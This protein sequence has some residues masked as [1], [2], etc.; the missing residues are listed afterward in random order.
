MAVLNARTVAACADVDRLLAEPYRQDRVRPILDVLASG[1][2]RTDGVDRFLFT[3][4]IWRCYWSLR[5]E[6][7]GFLIKLSNPEEIESSNYQPWRHSK[8]AYHCGWCD[9]ECQYVDHNIR[10]VSGKPLHH[11]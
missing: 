11:G 9:D 1:H 6:G 5:R 4:M 3:I 8:H 7:E 2:R 10:S